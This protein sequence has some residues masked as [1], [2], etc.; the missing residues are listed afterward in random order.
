MV[1]GGGIV[2]SVSAWR[3]NLFATA[4]AMHASESAGSN[5]RDQPRPEEPMTASS[6]FEST[7][8]D[9][10]ASNA[11]DV[12]VE[13]LRTRNI[14]LWVDADRLRYRAPPGAITPELIGRLK[15]H[16][17]ALLARFQI[18]RGQTIARLPTQPHYEVSHAQRRIWVLSQIEAASTAYN[19]AF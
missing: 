2:V 15:E 14:E 4:A 9:R 1:L 11:V 12:Q 3:S 18:A 8:N 17:D 10:S 13:Q 19:I 6:Q 7:K 5:S 16:K